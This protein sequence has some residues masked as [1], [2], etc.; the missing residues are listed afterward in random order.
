MW[1]EACLHCTC[2]SG[3]ARGTR[4]DACPWARPGLCLQQGLEARPEDPLPHIRPASCREAGKLLLLTSCTGKLS[5]PS[6]SAP[7]A[8]AQ[9]GIVCH[10]S[11]HLPMW[12]NVI[13]T[14]ARLFF[15]LEPL[16]A[17]L[18]R[19]WL[20]ASFLRL[21]PGMAAPRPAAQLLLAKVHAGALRASPGPSISFA[22]QMNTQPPHGATGLFVTSPLVS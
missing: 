3:G 21:S 4:W 19:G 12:K 9:P 8:E 20:I 22:K 6:S 11:M 1:D 14:R 5:C 7:R 13:T 16:P 17:V 2:L 18:V 10:R 15:P